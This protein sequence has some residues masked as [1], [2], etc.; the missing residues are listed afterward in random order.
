MHKSE[1]L[2]PGVPG[3]AIHSTS[4]SYFPLYK[5]FAALQ[6]ELAHVDSEIEKLVDSLT[7][8]TPVRYLPCVVPCKLY[9]CMS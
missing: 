5:K 1:I 8:A 6:V 3:K 4:F 7:G 9:F 2:C